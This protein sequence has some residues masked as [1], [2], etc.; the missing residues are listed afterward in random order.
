MLNLDA[1]R[2]NRREKAERRQ[3]KTYLTDDAIARLQSAADY[4]GA[5]LY[6]IVEALALTELPEV[7][8]PIEGSA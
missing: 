3:F 6:E 8:A 2:E 7:A 4:T 5:H 1:M